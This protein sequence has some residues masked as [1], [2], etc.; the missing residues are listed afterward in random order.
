M[1]SAKQSYGETV[2]EKIQSV[3]KTQGSQI[4]NVAGLIHKSLTSAPDAV[5]H[6]FG[7]GHSHMAVEE[8]F[9]RA[10]G[11]IPVNPWLESYLMP[12]AGPSRNGP[13]ERLPGLA[14]VIFDVYKPRKGEL[15]TIISNSGINATGIEM[16]QHAKEA[17][18]TTVAITNL[19]HSKST[20][21][22][23]ASGKKLFEVCDQVIDTGGVKGDAAIT[24]QGLDVPVGPLSSILSS[25]IINSLVVRICQI[26]SENG[27]VAPAY[28]SANLPGGD[29]RNRG[30]EAQFRSRIPR[31]Q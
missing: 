16:A 4:D 5:W 2:L 12:H 30:L 28:L 13:L 27:K 20:K 24:I 15:L 17:G 7:A 25:F 1:A 19:E 23:H 29:E 9:H 11:L 22:R 3:I 26:Y 10:G 14:R 21:S 31:L 8:A 6:L 18:V